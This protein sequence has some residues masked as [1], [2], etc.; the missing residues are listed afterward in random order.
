MLWEA[1]GCLFTAPVTDPGAQA[2][3]PGACRRTELDLLDIHP[4]IKRDR[5]VRIHLRCVAAPVTCTGRMRV[6]GSALAGT[7]R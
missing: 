5:K 6:L 2:P 4:V 1:N 3:E 7:V